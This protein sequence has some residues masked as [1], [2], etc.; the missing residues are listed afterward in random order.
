MANEQTQTVYAQTIHS[1]A[2]GK[3]GVYISRLDTS[4]RLTVYYCKDGRG[5]TVPFIERYDEG[6]VVK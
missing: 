6:T 4:G 1:S 5:A 3:G 2:D